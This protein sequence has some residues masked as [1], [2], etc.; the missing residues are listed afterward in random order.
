MPTQQAADIG[1]FDGARRLKSIINEDD[2]PP[3]YRSYRDDERDGY[4]AKVVELITPSTAIRELNLWGF[5]GNGANWGEDYKASGYGTITA[6]TGWVGSTPDVTD[7]YPSFTPP[8]GALTHKFVAWK[9]T[10]YNS[11]EGLD[12]IGD[13]A[14]K[15][16]SFVVDFDDTDYLW[17]QYTNGAP[18]T[19]GGE[20][21]FFFGSVMRTTAGDA[22]NYDYQGNLVLTPIPE[23]STVIV[24]SLL[25]SLAISIVL[26]RRSGVV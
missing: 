13:E 26:W 3:D 25:G 24:W 17:N 4:D 5:D 1:L 16:F 19:L 22:K 18:N 11:T 21:T 9:T 8:S 10:T 6:P 15:V 23:P 14:S 2:S 12:F 20:M 7:I